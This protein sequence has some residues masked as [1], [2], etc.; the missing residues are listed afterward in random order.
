MS[1]TCSVI[2][3]FP[4]YEGWVNWERQ[5][6]KA[7]GRGVLPGDVEFPEQ[8]RVIARDQAIIA[9]RR[10]LAAAVGCIRVDGNSSI[11]DIISSSETA[12]SKI[13]KLVQDAKIVSLKQI[14]DCSFE[15]IMQVRM[16]GGDGLIAAVLPEDD[17]V[18]GEGPHPAVGCTLIIDARNS[19]YCPSIFTRI[20]DNNGEILY[21]IS[22]IDKEQVIKNGL[23]SYVS[24]IK[25]AQ[26]DVSGN[27]VRIALKAVKPSQLT[28]S[29]I[30]LSRSDADR[31]TK[32]SLNAVVVI[33]SP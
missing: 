22:A 10:N 6:V 3:E 12:R 11:K 2:E 4:D 5:V 27:V 26:A 33:M 13:N 32:K 19:N 16:T 29:D 8:A 21:G 31:V 17:N 28:S 23:V 18:S 24:D 9:A 14:Y 1:A 20:T 30:I 7:I 25:K 15:V